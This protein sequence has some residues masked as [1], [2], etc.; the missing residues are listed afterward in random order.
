MLKASYLQIRELW[1]PNQK[2]LDTAD[3]A[4]SLSLPLF[5]NPFWKNF[6]VMVRNKFGKNSQ[7]YVIHLLL[8]DLLQQWD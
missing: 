7:Y 6:A 2:V 4:R 3:S 5:Y 8:P 1:Y